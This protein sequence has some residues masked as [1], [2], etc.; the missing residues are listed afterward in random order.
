MKNRKICDKCHAEIVFSKDD[1]LCEVD[2]TGAFPDIYVKSVRCP[3]CH[4]KNIL[5]YKNIDNKVTKAEYETKN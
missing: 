1:I 5:E 2:V 4:T 3:H